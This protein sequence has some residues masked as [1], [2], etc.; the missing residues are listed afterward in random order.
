MS[1]FFF[2]YL[3]FIVSHWCETSE[4]ICTLLQYKENQGGPCNITSHC[5]KKLVTTMKVYV[6]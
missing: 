2:T 4:H 5:C 6:R 1:S 3:L